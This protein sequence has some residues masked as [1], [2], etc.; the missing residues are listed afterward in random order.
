MSTTIF[1]PVGDAW[2]ACDVVC[3]PSLVLI[4]AA[5]PPPDPAFLDA[6]AEIV[7]SGI[8]YVA[9]IGPGAEHFHDALDPSI[10]R[11]I[12]GT[13]RDEVPMTAFSDCDHLETQYASSTT[14]TGT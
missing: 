3:V 12:A 14:S 10:I 5:A 9:F 4:L 2:A 11:R 1:R 7:V 6:L 8:A 13:A